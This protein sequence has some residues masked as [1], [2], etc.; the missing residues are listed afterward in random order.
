MSGFFTKGY[1]PFWTAFLLSL[2]VL[3]SAL[4][5]CCSIV[6]S[7]REEQPVDAAPETP[8]GV[9]ESFNL[10]LIGC[11]EKNQPPQRVTLLR[12]SGLDPQG[13]PAK[14][15]PHPN[16][17]RAAVHRYA[18]GAV[19]LRRPGSTGAGRPGTAGGHFG[20]LGADGRN[21]LMQNCPTIPLGGNLPVPRG[22]YRAVPVSGRAFGGGRPPAGRPVF[23]QRNRRGHAAVGNPTGTDSGHGLPRRPPSSCFPAPTPTFPP[24]IWS[25]TAASLPP[26]P[27]WCGT[28][29]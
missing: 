26:S 13:P 3:G 11:R 29:R 28:C 5:V 1:R 9:G 15:G 24:T 18:V 7:A 27:K 20:R 21:R 4:A 12:F 22:D 25:T 23:Q 17:H 6:F 8:V 2:L 14:R 19:P 16:R 10:L